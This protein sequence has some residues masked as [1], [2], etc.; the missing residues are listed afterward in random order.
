MKNF[1]ISS[2]IALIFFGSLT[3]NIKAEVPGKRHLKTTYRS[4]LSSLIE[5]ALEASPVLE[6]WMINTGHFYPGYLLR[7]N[8]DPPEN[9]EDWMINTGYFRE[10]YLIEKNDPPQ[11]IEKWMVNPGYFHTSYLVEEDDPMQNIEVWML[12][13]LLSK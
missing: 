3:E 4:D 5:D 7:E 12:S 8:N 10:D 2:V 13:C 1:I 9:I 11:N 6:N